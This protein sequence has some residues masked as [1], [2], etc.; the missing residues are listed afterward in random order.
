MDA[1]RFSQRFDRAFHQVNVQDL[2]YRP[3]GR[4]S[5][6]AG[7]SYMFSSAHGSQ[8][9]QS[10]H[11]KDILCRGSYID[12]V[13]R[14]IFNALE[15]TR[16]ASSNRF[17]ELADRV[18]RDTAITKQHIDRATRMMLEQVSRCQMEI[19]SSQWCFNFSWIALTVT[20]SSTVF[21]SFL[22]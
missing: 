22:E 9:E 12:S 5:A 17:E 1:K 7:P 18:S 21:V 14:E 19:L 8:E 16:S 15:A 13:P 10:T 2:R 11:A 3:K 4:T 20:A 6:T